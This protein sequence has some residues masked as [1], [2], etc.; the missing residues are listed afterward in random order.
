MKWGEHSEKAVERVERFATRLFSTKG[1][2]LLLALVAFLLL[3]NAS[4]KW[5]K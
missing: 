4:E 2:Y 3:S 1:L 5:G